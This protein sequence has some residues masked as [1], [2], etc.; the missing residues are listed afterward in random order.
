MTKK[1]KNVMILLL[2]FVVNETLLTR[3]MW[4]CFCKRSSKWVSV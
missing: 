1:K 2:L 3:Q 4:L